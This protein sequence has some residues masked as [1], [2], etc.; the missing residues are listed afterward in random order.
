MGYEVELFLNQVDEEFLCSICL[1]VFEYPV[2]VPCGHVF[3]RICIWN[4]LLD[5]E[6]CPVDRS[7]S[8][9]KDMARVAIPLKNI[10][11]RLEIKCR[12]EGCDHVFTLARIDS[13]DMKCPL[14]PDPWISCHL[15]TLTFPQSMK[16]RHPCN[17]TV[18]S[19]LDNI[20]REG[21]LAETAA[22]SFYGR[23]S[24]LRTTPDHQAV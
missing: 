22:L 6:S 8:L 23:S 7:P 15:C 16:N 10:L 14:N 12:F 17:P 1:S 20:R 9:I 3:C 5:H 19:I 13:H 11:D 21:N 24:M 4:W 18:K 2:Q